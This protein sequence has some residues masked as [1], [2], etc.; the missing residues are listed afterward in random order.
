MNPRP[1]EPRV[2][3]LKLRFDAASVGLEM[4]ISIVLG[5]LLGGWV[6]G[7]LDTAPWGMVFFLLC[8]VAAGF[9]GLIRV[10]H[11]VQ[12]DARQKARAEALA[13]RGDTRTR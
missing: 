4:A 10:H 12:A 3:P 9:K 2:K 7:Q 1:N 13:L 8:G 5:Y 11:Q 6:D